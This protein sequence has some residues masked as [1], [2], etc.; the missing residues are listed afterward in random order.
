MTYE[1][2]NEYVFD[3]IKPDTYTFK[4][5]FGPVLWSGELTEAQLISSDDQS[6]TISEKVTELG[7]GTEV[8]GAMNFKVVPGKEYG[9]IVITLDYDKK[10]D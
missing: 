7:K 3:S 10:E 4:H 5:T 6:P 9:K 8:T 2:V 1:G